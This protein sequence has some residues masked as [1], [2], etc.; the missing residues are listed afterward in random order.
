MATLAVWRAGARPTARGPHRLSRAARVTACDARRYA[1]AQ[2]EGGGAV[3]P[4]AT[5]APQ[6]HPPPVAVGAP[7]SRPQSVVSAL[8]PLVVA[9]AVLAA[10]PGAASAAEGALPAP[11][12]D[13]LVAWLEAVEAAGPAGGA[14][15]CATVAL[16]ELVP[17]LPTTPL[18]LAA[19]LLFGAP[20]GAALVLTGNLLAA[21]GAFAIARGVGARFAAR[22]VSAEG[23]GEPSSRNP[24]AARFAAVTAAVEAGTPAQ[25]FAAV[26]ALRATPVVPFSARWARGRGG[27]WGARAKEKTKND[28]NPNPPSNYVLGLSPIPFAIYLP[29]TAAGGA[30]WAGVYSSIGAASRALLARG[31]ALD[32]LVADLIDQAGALADDAAAGLAVAGAAVAVGWLALRASRARA[33]AGEGAAPGRGGPDA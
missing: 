14:L 31:A 11:A 26:F 24:L 10:T 21:S 22:V 16:A 17:L 33:A 13:A 12:L 32:G 25:Q 23:G 9:A 3:G 19:G 27:G 1:P 6:N 4:R 28:P 30:V 2:C 8:A 15:F 29:A 20:K 5:R 7:C 18:A